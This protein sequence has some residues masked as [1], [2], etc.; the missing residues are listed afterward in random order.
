MIAGNMDAA[1]KAIKL[2]QNVGVWNSLAKM[3]VKTRRLDVAGV[4]LGHMANA[5]AARAVRLAVN[6]DSLPIE[7]KLAVLAI[8]L[9][10]LVGLPYFLST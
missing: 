1:F 9:G 4:C 5:R 2:V 3:C 6:D 7:A 8:Q 10:M